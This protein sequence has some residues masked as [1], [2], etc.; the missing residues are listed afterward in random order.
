[1]ATDDFD[2]LPNPYRPPAARLDD[3]PSAG[4][5]FHSQGIDLEVDNPWLTIWTRPRATIRGVVDRDP[6]YRVV[7]LAAAAGVNLVLNRLIEQLPIAGLPF[8]VWIV[9]AIV[10]GPLAGLL[11]L[12]IGGWWFSNMGRILGGRARSKE[13]RTAIAWSNVPTLAAAPLL[14]AALAVLQGNVSAAD[15]PDAGAAAAAVVLFALVPVQTVLGLWSTVIFFKGLG[16][17]HGFSAWRALACAVLPILVV[18][19]PLIVIA[20]IALVLSH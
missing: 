14:I 17:V 15:S 3:A 11:Q 10:L 20:G 4:S 19:V 6:T 9:A 18:L 8:S 2:D 7:P 12:F 5:S 1:M 16:E 13:V